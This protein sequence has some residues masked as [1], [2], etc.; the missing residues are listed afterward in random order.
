MTVQ[1]KA[2]ASEIRRRLKAL[3]A[4]VDFHRQWSEGALFLERRGVVHGGGVAVHVNDAAG[5]IGG[6]R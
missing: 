4:L 1:Q 3:R 2:K 6:A 5:E